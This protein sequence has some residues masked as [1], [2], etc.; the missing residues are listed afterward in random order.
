MLSIVVPIYNTEKYLE[1]C[2]KSLV[3]QSCSN[4]LEVILVNDG[5]TD[6]SQVIIDE[7]VSQYPKIFKAYTK[8][9][10]GLSDARNYGVKYI[11]GKYL[12]FLDSDDWVDVNLYDECVKHLEQNEV[13]FVNFNYIEEYGDRKKTVDCRSKMYRSKYFIPVVAWNKVFKSS[14]WFENRFQFLS[15]VKHEDVELIPKVIFFAKNIG[16]LDNKYAFIHYERTNI[17]SITMLKR[18]T[19]SWIKVADS[20]IQFSNNVD[21]INFTK[22]TASTLFYQFILFGGNPN[23]SWKLYCQNKIFFNSN[24]VISRLHFPLSIIQSLKCDYVILKPI[25]NLLHRFKVRVDR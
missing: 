11:S 9:N 4:S 14:F 12:A 8:E 10:G 1:R 5:S 13:D 18:D 19:M 23:F 21:D 16:F 22:F 2:L 6:H 3:H 25:I 24:N 15:G 17:N 7:F 20:L